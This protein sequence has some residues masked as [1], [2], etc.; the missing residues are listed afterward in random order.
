MKYE[1]ALA[2]MEAVA[3]YGIVPGL[4][5]IRELCRRLGN[6]QNALKFVHIAGTNGKGSTLCFIS[7]ILSC[8]G[9]RVGRYMSPVIFNYRE[10][11]QVGK[12]SITKTSL[13]EGVELIKG[14]CEEM[15]QEGFGHP[16]VFEIETALAFWY[17][18]KKQCDIVVLETG[19]GGLS[20]ATNLIETTQVAVLT[21]IGMDH[22][23]FLGK[24]ITEIASQKAGIIKQGCRVVCMQQSAEVLEVIGRVAETFACPFC[25]ADSSK[26]GHVRYGIEK[27]RFDY[28]QWKKLEITLAGKFQID[29]A[30][31]ALEA[32]KALG[33]MGFSVSEA[34]IRKGLK[35]AVWP[36]RF[37]LIGKKPYFIVDGAH[38]EDAAQKLAESIEFYFTNKRIIYIMGILK[39]K[40]YDK[41][42]ALTEKYADQIIT[43]T[44]PENPRAMHSYDLAKEIAPM[45]PNVT[46]VDSLEEAVEI[47]Y[48]LAGKDDVIIAFGSLSY[49]GRLINMVAHHA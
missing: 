36:G 27:Q 32:V 49:L 47:S 5:N 18:Q 44:P 1:E 3:G 23:Q 19:M 38:N 12:Q 11:I 26:A 30:V 2:Y 48:L 29:N 7:T 25:I 35:E 39:D 42:I 21:S 10:R 34:A 6:P 20:D 37:Q 22:M 16:T 13:C 17:F 8:A 46:A 4:D 41:V 45:H 43:V 15:V 28:G 14:I 40:E 33:E 9:Y 24:N 31:L